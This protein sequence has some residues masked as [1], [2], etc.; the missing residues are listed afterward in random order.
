MGRG[1]TNGHRERGLGKEGRERLVKRLTNS[2]FIQRARQKWT[3][4]R[5]GAA[6]GD[7]IQ[8]LSGRMRCMT[9]DLIVVDKLARLYDWLEDE[10]LCYVLVVIGRGASVV[11]LLAWN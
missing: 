8:A 11:T 10:M 6:I 9:A 4:R 2:A 5:A 3:A 1:F 7:H